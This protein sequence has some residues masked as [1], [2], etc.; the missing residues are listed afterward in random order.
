MTQQADRRIKRDRRVKKPPFFSIYLIKGRRER[1]RRREDRRPFQRPDR[2][3]PQVI[4]LMLTVIGLS[5]LDAFFTLMLME[6]GARE[7]NP[8]MAYCL[9][10]SPTLFI[11]VKY[12][13]TAASV[14]TV[15]FIKDAYLFKTRTPAKILFFLIMIPFMFVIPW[16]LHLILNGF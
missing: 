13:L 2:Y 10:Q 4:F 16:Q 3:S 7:I 9:E 8:I 12:C 14:I 5:L 11:G 15:L 1:F 6:R